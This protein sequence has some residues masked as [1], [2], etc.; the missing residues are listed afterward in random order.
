ML[1][2]FFVCGLVVCI[3]VLL[4]LFV[5]LFPCFV[6]YPCCCLFVVVAFVDVYL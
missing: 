3:R 1:C 2:V 4:W 5:F 6:A